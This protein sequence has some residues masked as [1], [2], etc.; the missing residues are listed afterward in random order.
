MDSQDDVQYV[1]SQRLLK[2]ITFARSS[3]FFNFHREYKMMDGPQ[4]GLTT[5]IIDV[6]NH[7]TGVL[8]ERLT[9][10]M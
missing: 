7:V 5:V 4:A 6:L 2:I 1:G 3:G 10:A 8:E 9:V